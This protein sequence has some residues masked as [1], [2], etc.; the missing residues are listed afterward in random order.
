[1]ASAAANGVT[2]L[3]GSEDV[4]GLTIPTLTAAILYNLKSSNTIIGL[5]LTYLRD[6]T[7]IE[8]LLEATGLIVLTHVVSFNTNL[9]SIQPARMAP[10]QPAL[11]VQR[12]EILCSTLRDAKIPK[13]SIT[14][15]QHRVVLY[16]LREESLNLWREMVTVIFNADVC[17][18]TILFGVEGLLFGSWRA[19]PRFHSDFA[20]SFEVQRSV[21]C[22]SGLHHS[23]AIT[24]K[25]ASTPDTIILVTCPVLPLLN[26]SNALQDV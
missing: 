15:R 2:I 5:L 6:S 22:K 1:M 10:K 12:W 8:S 18:S 3:K 13:L 14:S 26:S 25:E 7:R 9:L 16:P 11:H 17:D 21:T 24:H 4:S 20:R 23:I 19:Y